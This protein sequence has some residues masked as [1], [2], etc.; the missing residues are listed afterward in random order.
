VLFWICDAATAGVG[1][2]E[3]YA[4]LGAWFGNGDWFW[5]GERLKYW[6]WTSALKYWLRVDAAVLDNGN[7]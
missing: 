3:G 4:G 2:V 6:F 5:F 1:G 7:G